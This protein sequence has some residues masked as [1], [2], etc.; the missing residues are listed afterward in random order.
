MTRMVRLLL[1]TLLVT[2]ACWFIVVTQ[3]HG[4]GHGVDKSIEILEL[5]PQTIPLHP[6]W[7][8]NVTH[9]RGMR[10]A[11]IAFEAG[12]GLVGAL[13]GPPIHLWKFTLVDSAYRYAGGAHR[14]RQQSSTVPIIEPADVVGGSAD[15]FAWFLDRARGRIVGQDIGGHRIIV[16]HLQSE[17]AAHSAC[18]L[19]EESIAFLEEQR[20]GLVVVQE[21]Q[22]GAQRQ[23]AIPSRGWEDADV[24]WRSVR[25]DGALLGRCVLWSPRMR[26][27]F[28][29]ADSVIVPIRPPVEPPHP[30]S[31]H[32]GLEASGAGG[33]RR[34][35]ESHESA[36]VT[37]D[38]T[39]SASGV[40]LLL[41]GRLRVA[42][43]AVDFYDDSGGYLG[44]VRLARRASR[45]AG[46]RHRLIALSAGS[47]SVYITS[48]VLPA[49]MRRRPLE[50]EANVSVPAAAERR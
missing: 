21:I 32:G 34:N 44:T 10:F 9:L 18:A 46:T 7:E 26:E 41:G 48:Y 37:L 1:A 22:S 13:Q 31:D 17:G 6:E 23:L 45:I 11:S 42:G 24:T 19:N 35:Q 16:A 25:L 29:V 3:D 47:D 33:A 40:A 39:S 15:G 27:V 4:G 30:D 2:G 20:P 49:R 5:R 28:I 14:L 50:E 8:R 43:R 38:A 36:V 12:S